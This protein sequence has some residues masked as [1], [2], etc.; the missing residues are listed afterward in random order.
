MNERQAIAK[1][2]K[3]IGP[4]LAWRENRRA[5]DANAR[6]E[7]SLRA[8]ELRIQ[9]RAAQ[10][11]LEAK[12]AELLRDPEYV[13]LRQKLQS[14]KE[15]ADV[16]LSQSRQRKITV[17]KLSGVGGV[18]FFHVLAEGDDWAEVVEK[19]CSA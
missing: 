4:K 5:L 15:E 8:K 13:A 1:L 2:K 12:R 17:G 14:I 16:A 9:Q 3:I 18:E 10:E 11:A 6:E 19:A 7:K